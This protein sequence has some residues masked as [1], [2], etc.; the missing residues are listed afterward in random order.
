[1]MLYYKGYYGTKLEFEDYYWAQFIC[2][3][4]YIKANMLGS[5]VVTSAN[6]NE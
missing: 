4:S 1:M 3:Y 6:N 2:A 5:K